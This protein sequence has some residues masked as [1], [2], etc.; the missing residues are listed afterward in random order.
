MSPNGSR[1]T[2]ELSDHSVTR[3]AMPETI[4]PIATSTPTIKTMTAGLGS[5]SLLTRR[6]LPEP[7]P[8]KLPEVLLAQPTREPRE[9]LLGEAREVEQ[10]VERA[11]A[12]LGQ[13]HVGLRDD[14]RVARRAI[15]EGEVAEEPAGA[16]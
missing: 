2:A 1:D 16:E 9:Q 14:A 12:D 6:K 4:V 3:G 10:R 11:L 8:S 5:F 7:G 15:E 13:L